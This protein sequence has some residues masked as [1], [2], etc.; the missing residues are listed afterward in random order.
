MEIMKII[1][2]FEWAPRDRSDSSDS[3]KYSESQSIDINSMHTVT[4]DEEHSIG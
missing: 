2:F 1:S 4:K 3:S